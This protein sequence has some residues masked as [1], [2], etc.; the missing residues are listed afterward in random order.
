MGPAVCIEFELSNESIDAC[1]K[2]SIVACVKKRVL[3]FLF[4][5]R[6]VKAIVLC[7]ESAVS[8]ER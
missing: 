6:I 5:Y 1:R 4:G 8:R 2:C 3:V 7:T